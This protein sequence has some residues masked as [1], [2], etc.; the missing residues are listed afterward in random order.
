V[1]ESGR[2]SW[3]LCQNVYPPERPDEQSLSVALAVT[4]RMLKG[5]GAC[6]VHGGGFAGTILTFVPQ[7]LTA[8]YTAKMDDL[9]GQ[10][11]ARRLR[12]R[13]SGAD[14]ILGKE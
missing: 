14:E 4:D 8:Q 11:A 12:I 6:R 7:E 9:F 13:S 3:M 2:S 1:S 10:G 5:R